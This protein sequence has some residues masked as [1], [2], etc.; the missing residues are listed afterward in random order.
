MWNVDVTCI[1]GIRSGEATLRPGPN[2]VQA[3]NFQGKSSFL[4][5][6]QTAIG[7]TGLL[8][9]DH[10]LMENEDDGKVT[11]ETD[12]E[13]YTVSLTRATD[14][15]EPAISRSGTPYLTRDQDQIAARLFAVLGEDNPI[16]AAVRE[17]NQER[18]TELLKKPLETE[19]IDLRIEALQREI[20]ELEDEVAAAEAASADLP[21]AQQKVTRLQGELRDLNET[22]DELERKVDEET[23]QR[24]LRDELTAKQSD[25]E[26]EE[27]RLERLENQV[28]RRKAQ[29]DDKEAALESLDIPDS[30][31]AEADIAEKQ[32]RIDELAVKIDLLDDLHR[33]TKAIIDEGEIDLIT[34]VE[35]TLSGD[36]FSCF[37]CGAETTA[38]AVTERLNEISDR[39]ES[40][41]EQRATLTEEVTQMQ[42]RTR[43]IESKRQQKAELEDEIKRLRVDI[44]ED[45]HEVRS[46]EATIEELQAEIEQREAEYEA[47]EKAG[48]SHSAELKT[49]QQKIGSTETKLDRAQAELERI[50]AELQKRNDRQE[51]LETKRDELETLRQRRK[52]KYNE[53]VNQFDAAMADIIGRFAP[54]FD[55]AYLDQ[56]TDANDTVGFEINLARDGHTTDLDTLSEGERELV[57]IVT[58]LAGYRTFSVGDRV[59]C[60][61][62]DG[63]GQLAAEHIRHMIEYLEN[64]AEIL[65]TTAY[66]EAGSFDG[67]TVSPEH[68]D[69]I[70]HETA[71]SRDHPQITN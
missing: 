70:S 35:R 60:I 18:L 2:I 52:Q 9:E 39:Q 40:L 65:V 43:E 7:T 71:Q 38:E 24:A 37:V 14:S 68:W 63:I 53:L 34:D 28:D 27:A 17:E 22:R 55:G 19:N 25:L 5:A 47:A 45:Q 30:P 12:E 11:L 6:I 26:R 23:D 41:R 50:E 31:T 56:K 57:G 8:T 42:Q 64:T 20:K 49:I 67:E 10:P 4:A 15:D 16:R 1:G 33:S 58:A 66:P 21:A 36:T 61:L 13:T 62:L 3:S 69:V 44:Q 54:G 29:L 59:P 48:E 46:I 32:T 51:Q